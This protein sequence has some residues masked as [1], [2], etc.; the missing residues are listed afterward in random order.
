MAAR[1]RASRTGVAAGQHGVQAAHQLPERLVLAPGSGRS[2]VVLHRGH[3]APALDGE[4]DHLG[5]HQFASPS[6]GLGSASAASSAAS[7]FA[8]STSTAARTISSLVLNWW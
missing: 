3:H 5:E 8:R 7:S 4:V 1:T 6:A 2:R